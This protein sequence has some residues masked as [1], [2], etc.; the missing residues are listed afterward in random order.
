MGCV[1][2]KYKLCTNTGKKV[3]RKEKRIIIFENR[4]HKYVNS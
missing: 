2:T 3:R 1:L 4:T